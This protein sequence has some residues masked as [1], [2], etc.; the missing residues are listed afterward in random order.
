MWYCFVTTSSLSFLRLNIST[1]NFCAAFLL[2]ANFSLTFAT[3]RQ[4]SISQSAPLK[5]CTSSILKCHLLSMNMW[6]TWLWV[7]PRGEVQEY[8]WMFQYRN[9]MFL[10][11]FFDVAKFTI[12][13][14]LPLLSQCRLILNCQFEN[15][16]S[17]QFNSHKNCLLNHHFS[18]HLV[19]AHSKRYYTCDLSELHRTPYH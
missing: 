16:L 6:S 14:P 1:S 12:L 9:I 8:L 5:D 17:P 19:H 2:T 15:I 7:F 18:P 10:T 3:T 4:W 11:R 13:T